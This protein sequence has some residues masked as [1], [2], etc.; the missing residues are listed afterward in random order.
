V[1]VAELGDCGHVDRVV[2]PPV[3]AQRQAM[4]LPVP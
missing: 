3:A 4:D 2:D 1:L